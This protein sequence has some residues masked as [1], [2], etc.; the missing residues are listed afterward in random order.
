VVVVAV[1]NSTCYEIA[2][3]VMAWSSYGRPILQIGIYS[4]LP[5]LLL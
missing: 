3:L 5:T 4:Q 2:S 1:Y